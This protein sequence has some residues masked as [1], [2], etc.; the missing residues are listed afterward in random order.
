MYNLS[1]HHFRY[2]VERTNSFIKIWF[3]S[4]AATGIPS[5]VTSGGTS[6]NT[7]NWVR[8]FLLPP[9]LSAF[10][11]LYH[12]S[13]NQGTPSAYFPSTSCPISSKFGPHN[14]VINCEHR[15][16]QRHITRLLTNILLQWRSVSGFLDL[17]RGAV[18]AF[19]TP[20]A[21]FCSSFIFKPHTG[22]DWA[23]SSSVYAASGCPSTC[24][25]K[26]IFDH[27]ILCRCVFS[28]HH[29]RLCE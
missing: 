8:C 27:H 23:G 21:G 24:V 5:D 17:V 28:P 18:V 3:W 12:A 2:A 10:W 9:A 22:G 20:A 16:K 13:L 4:R 1:I 14:I 15:N 6:V 25:S 26:W 29:Y 11:C 19:I 7:D